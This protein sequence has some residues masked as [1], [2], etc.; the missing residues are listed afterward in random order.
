[1]INTIDFEEL[2][3]LVAQ[4][5]SHILEF[6][7][8]T[9][10]L[11]AAFETLCGF[12][13]GH[14]GTVLIG[15]TDGGKILGQHVSDETR[16]DIAKEVAKIEPPIEI[17]ITYIP[18]GDGKHVIALRTESRQYPPYAFDARPF[19]RNQSTTSKMPQHQYEQLL[20]KRNHI[21]YAW[22]DALASGYEID[23]LDQE[24]ILRTIKEGVDQNRIGVEVLNYDIAHILSTLKLLR[25]GRLTNAAVVL[26]AKEIHGNYSNCMIRMARFRGTDKT[27]DFI[28]NQRAQGNAFRLMA[29]ANDFVL[30]HLP[31]ASFFDPS[32]MQR[33]DQPAVP[34]LALREALA[35]AIVHRDYTNRSASIALAIFDDRLEIWN[36]GKLPVQLKIDD[37]RKPHQSYPRNERIATV[38]Y[39]RGWVEGWGTGTV[40]MIGYC[41]KNG[42]PEPD[43]QEDSG[44]L[45][46]TFKF[47]EPMGRPAEV[48]TELSYKLTSRQHEVLNILSGGA[49]MTLN[50]ISSKLTN[51]PAPRTLRD[52]LAHLKSLGIIDLEGRAKTSKWFLTK[53]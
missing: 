28:D 38:F 10:Q 25:D 45:A 39:E 16:Q 12:L 18:V 15:V 43:F 35:N 7:K 22:D 41:Q 48:S 26:Y 3:T 51:P 9:T 17:S 24:E 37:L 53:K 11:K 6:K 40:R 42:T 5:E 27:G 14:G 46:V 44:G 30:R 21:N 47:K 23:D 13:N 29:A 34:A 32:K 33:I 8:S 19:T 2:K 20:V 4:G 31:I 1:M 52:D 49:K 36:N 50:D